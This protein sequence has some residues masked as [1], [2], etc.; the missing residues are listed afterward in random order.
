M[1]MMANTYEDGIGQGITSNG[2]GMVH[3]RCR[4][5]R[6]EAVGW[7]DN[8]FHRRRPAVTRAVAGDSA[9]MM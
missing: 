7:H 4:G 6:P 5:S 3:A 8:R 9:E 2:H 1:T